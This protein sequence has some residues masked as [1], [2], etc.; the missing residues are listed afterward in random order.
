MGPWVVFCQ[1]NCIPS[2]MGTDLSWGIRFANCLHLAQ[3]A[4]VPVLRPQTHHPN[5]LTTHVEATIDCFRK[6]L[7]V[8]CVVALRE[9]LQYD[10]I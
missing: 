6:P 10:D 4:G 9:T 7:H 5:M 3:S 1:I 8:G 2:D